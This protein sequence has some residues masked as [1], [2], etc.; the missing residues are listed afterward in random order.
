MDRNKLK[1][2][3][4]KACSSDEALDRYLF[5]VGISDVKTFMY[6]VGTGMILVLLTSGILWLILA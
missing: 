1:K 4:L 6:G 2:E 3:M 5:E